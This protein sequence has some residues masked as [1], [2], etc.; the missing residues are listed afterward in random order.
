MSD[1]DTIDMQALARALDDMEWWEDADAL[2]TLVAEVERLRGALTEIVT[3]PISE[4]LSAGYH[5]AEV[6]SIARAALDG[7]Q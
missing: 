4:D 7:K 1:P 3:F 6:R 5:F 2:R